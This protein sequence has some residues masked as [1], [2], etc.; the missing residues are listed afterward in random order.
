VTIF[1]ES[2][3]GISVNVLM[4]SP[5]ARGLFHQAIA[6]SSFGR[7]QQETLAESEKSSADEA[8]K[9]GVA[10]DSDA[11]A[12][13]A[14]PTAQILETSAGHNLY[15]YGRAPIVDGKLYPRHVM[16]T[17][18]QG[19][20]APVPYIV[21]TTSGEFPSL[22]GAV[23]NRKPSSASLPAD[24]KAAYGSEEVYRRDFASDALL[25]E[26]AATLAAYHVRRAPTYRYN[27]AV[28]SD[29]LQKV[30][31]AAPHAS[32]LPF[33]F[34]TYDAPGLNMSTRDKARGAEIARY[35]T[36]F[37]R[38]G[39]PNDPQLPEWPLANEGRVVVFTNDGPAPGADP[40]TDRVAAIRA[41]TPQFLKPLVRPVD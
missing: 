13:R 38:S 26:P 32:E 6:E 12:L 24:L 18:A 14:V 17:F 36:N 37:A 29:A 30:L 25:V 4:T 10:N 7:E 34:Q 27:F 33:V 3:G 40:A 41:A 28:M 5:L 20:E 35:W 21:G 15:G 9:W 22:P 2:A 1:G 8:A 11:T 19:L 31:K 23:G 16:E 39:S